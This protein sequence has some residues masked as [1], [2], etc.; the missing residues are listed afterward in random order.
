MSNEPFDIDSLA[1]FLHLTP[2][3][4]ARMADRGKVPGRKVSG[5]WKFS[6]AEIHH[7]FEER[8]GVSDAEELAEVEQ[9]LQRQ[10]PT[11]ETYPTLADMLQPAAVAP[12]LNARSPRAVIESICDLAA[13]TG[14]L[15]DPPKMVEAVKAR[16]E[17]H[18]TALEG[19]VALLHP[20]RPMPHIL[21]EPILALAKT[22]GGIPFGGSGGA[23]TDIFFLI[24][25]YSERQHLHTLARLSR[26]LSE[27]DFIPQLRAAEQTGELVAIVAQA[28]EAVFGE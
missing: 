16:E 9:T 5:Q 19:G 21:G 27:A 26:L 17:L 10:R 20:R 1:A 14:Q 24:A 6:R 7:W 2:Q 11:G 22:G 8:I 4:V 15:W 12:L 28:E 25:S 13:Q 18:P 3:Q 23:L